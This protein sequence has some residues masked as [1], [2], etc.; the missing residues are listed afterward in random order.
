LN[1]A[2]KPSPI[3]EGVIEIIINSQPCKGLNLTIRHLRAGR[4]P[5]VATVNNTIKES[6]QVLLR[7]SAIFHAYISTNTLWVAQTLSYCTPIK[8][9]KVSSNSVTHEV[10]K[11]AG[12][13]KSRMC[14]YVIKC[15]LIRTQPTWSLI[16]TCGGYHLGD[17]DL[18]SSPLSTFPSSI[19]HFPLIAPSD[20]QLCQHLDHLAKPT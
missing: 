7:P 12:P 20:L 14:Q 11:F 13:H 10:T 2:I 8:R 19:L 6:G 18:R 15:L 9:G 17:S 1:I 4:V 16:D 3:F 5:Q